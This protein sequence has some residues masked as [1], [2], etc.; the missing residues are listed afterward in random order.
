[1]TAGLL[2]LV[3]WSQAL[4]LQLMDDELLEAA[5][6]ECR[7]DMKKAVNHTQS[8]FAALRTGRAAP[9]LVERIRVEY[10]G[11]EVP[12]QQMA[13]ISV[14]EARLLVLTPYDKSTLGTIEKAILQS[15][16][17]IT[18]S[19]DGSV[20]RLAFPQ[21]TEER[22]KELVK[23]AKAKAE[24][25]RI[26]VRNARRSCRQGLE[27]FEKDGEMSSD[28]LERAEKQLDGVTKNHVDEIDRLLA[29]KEKEL[30]EV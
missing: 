10:F 9:A 30:L 28:E 26:A 8:E 19:N 5:F 2:R 16:L 7:G 18:P 3:T 13:G 29:Q 20:I 25:G 21:L 12:L 11:T 4:A 14:P 6:D 15:D 1:V 22:R 27:R 17:G 23:V 24:E